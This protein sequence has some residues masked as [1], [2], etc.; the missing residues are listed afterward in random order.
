MET[1]VWERVLVKATCVGIRVTEMGTAG[2]GE[3]E[4]IYTGTQEA[5]KRKKQNSVLVLWYQDNLEMD[6]S[7]LKYVCVPCQEKFF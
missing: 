3:A 5:V 2:M 4:V 7:N 1:M 6:F